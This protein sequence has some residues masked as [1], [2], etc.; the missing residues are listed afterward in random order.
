MPRFLC[1]SCKEVVEL[2]G[3]MRFEWCTAC[4]EPMGPEDLLHV[5]LSPPR[6]VAQA[7]NGPVGSGAELAAPALATTTSPIAASSRAPSV[8]PPTA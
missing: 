7:S 5:R 8:S 3:S 4:G 1:S 6:T 2:S